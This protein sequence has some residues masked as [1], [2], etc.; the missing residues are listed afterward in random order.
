MDTTRK[1]ISGF[2]GMVRAL[3]KI[4]YTIIRNRTKSAR[5]KLIP[6]KTLD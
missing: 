6:S 3:L 5:E 4:K 2:D 1:K